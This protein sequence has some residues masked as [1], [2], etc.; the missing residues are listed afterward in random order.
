AIAGCR[1]GGVGRADEVEHGHM[2]S[3]QHGIM[4]VS[5]RSRLLG[6]ATAGG[7]GAGD[8]GKGD[9]DQDTQSHGGPPE[10]RSL[11][12][13]CILAHGPKKGKRITTS[14][15]NSAK[16]GKKV[17]EREKVPVIIGNG[18]TSE[19][20]FS[21]IRRARFSRPWLPPVRKVAVWEANDRGR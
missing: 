5:K 19:R 9:E 7:G 15:R 17:L 21:H 4:G 6:S 13:A 18:I 10:Q 1:M 11:G 8:K 16:G 2:L 12:A 20:P 3:L 14:G